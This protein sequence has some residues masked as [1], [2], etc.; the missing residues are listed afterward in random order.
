MLLKLGMFNYHL[1]F[2]LL[3]L[4]KRH[5]GYTLNLFELG[6]APWF[7]VILSLN[8]LEFNICIKERIH[9]LICSKIILR[10]HKG[11]IIFKDKV[12]WERN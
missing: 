12:I 6:F 3:Y 11:Q 2:G 4:Y 5:N 7:Y 1:F 9:G 10:L 8:P